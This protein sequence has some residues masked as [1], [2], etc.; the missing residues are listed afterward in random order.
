MNPKELTRKSKFISLVLRH[1]PGGIGIALDTNGRVKIND[2]IDAMNRHGVS[3]NREILDE[4]VRTNDKKRYVID[5]EYIYAAQGHSIHNISV[6]M[7]EAKPSPVLFHGTSSKNLDS[8]F[9][10]GINSGNRN[11]VHLSSDVETATKVGSRHGKAVVLVIATEQ[12]HVDGFKFYLSKNGIWLT[13]HIPSNYIN[14]II[15]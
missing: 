15:N 6:E 13:E 7:E 2:L 14:S 10:N 5:G 1:D 12:M 4:I 8:I 9:K 3:I 11:H